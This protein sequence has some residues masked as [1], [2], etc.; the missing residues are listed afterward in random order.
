LDEANEFDLSRED[1]MLPRP[2]ASFSAPEV[3][4]DADFVPR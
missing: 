1:C 2:A 3:D 4:A